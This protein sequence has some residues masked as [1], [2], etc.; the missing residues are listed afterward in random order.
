ML[1]ENIFSVRI[2]SVSIQFTR[3]SDQTTEF[4]YDGSELTEIA[5]SHRL[6][7]PSENSMAVS[8]YV[9]NK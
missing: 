9:S 6:L 3:S 5:V 2:C 4:L 8:K 1:Q 7:P